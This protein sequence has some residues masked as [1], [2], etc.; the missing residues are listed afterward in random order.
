MMYAGAI[1]NPF[2][3]FDEEKF[4]VED[5]GEDALKVLSEKRLGLAGNK[6]LFDLLYEGI[7]SQVYNNIIADLKAN[8]QEDADVEYFKHVYNDLNPFA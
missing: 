1:A 8:L 4:N 7:Y 6:T 5:L 2:E 3:A